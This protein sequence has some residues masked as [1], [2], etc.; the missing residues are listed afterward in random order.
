MKKYE[1]L[2]L[3]QR[4]TIE[5]LLK[6]GYNQKQIS[7]AIGK[8][9]S[10]ISRELKRNV[11]KR[12]K[13]AGVYCFERAQLKTEKRHKDKPKHKR[14][15]G[16]HLEFIRKKLIE[17]KWSPEYISER[18]KLLYGDFVSHE[19]IYN[20]IWKCK[21]S[22]KKEYQKDKN[23]HKYLRHHKRRQKRKNDKQN[24]G[25]IP[26]RVSIEKRPKLVNERKRKGDL[27]VDLMMGS[28]HKPGLIVITDRKTIE[29][30]LIKITTKKAKVIAAKIIKKLKTEESKLFT[31][32]FDNGL[33]FAEHQKIAK[34]LKVKTY[35][36]RPYT[37]QDKGTVENRIGVIRRFF[38]KGTD[39]SKVHYNTIK[40][41]ERKLNNRPLRKFNYLTPLEKKNSIR[42]IALIT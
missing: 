33:E 39:M 14:L 3:S 29:T 8:S 32:T 26:N 18:G 4:Y 25:C 15:E 36:T 22:N 17:E 5:C 38:P 31:L 28:K 23:L 6:E 7:I 20:Y 10:T 40:S 12:G 37:S 35:F 27:E 2:S 42:K 1:Q 34:L 41:V 16:W 9:E 21:S 24:R 19:T 11:N 30:K 13:H